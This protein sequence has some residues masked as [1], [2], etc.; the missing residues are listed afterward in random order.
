[1]VQKI[2]FVLPS[3]KKFMEKE[4]IKLV[5]VYL[6]CISCLEY[7][8]LQ[9]L[10]MDKPVPN[11]YSLVGTMFVGDKNIQIETGIFTSVEWMGNTGSSLM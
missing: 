10:N 1:M 3:L 9:N 2:N 5:G 8:W 6:D 7:F 4:S 11:K